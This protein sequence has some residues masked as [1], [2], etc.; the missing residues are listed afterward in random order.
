MASRFTFNVTKMANCQKQ[1]PGSNS[2]GSYSLINLINNITSLKI[3]FECKRN[4]SLEDYESYKNQLSLKYPEHASK[5]NSIN[6]RMTKY[7][8]SKLDIDDTFFDGIIN[9]DSDGEYY[10]SIFGHNPPHYTTVIVR[11]IDS[12]VDIIYCDTANR[13]SVIRIGDEFYR[14]NFLKTLQK[15]LSSDYGGSASYSG[16]EELT[17]AQIQEQL[18]LLASLGDYKG[19]S[20]SGGKKVSSEKQKLTSEDIRNIKSRFPLYLNEQLISIYED[21]PIVKSAGEFISKY[22]S[23]LGGGSKNNISRRYKI[24]Y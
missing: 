3:P 23:L 9:K 15:Y 4:L 19:S 12:N 6:L 20:A 11:I 18:S 10:F 13:E 17:E 1:I 22:S 8:S 5:I 16:F 24:L 21:D 2:C 7:G 14:N